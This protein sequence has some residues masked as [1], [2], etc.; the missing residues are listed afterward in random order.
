MQ[1]HCS[2]DL[3]FCLVGKWAQAPCEACGKGPGVSWCSY[4]GVSVLW[5]LR[6]ILWDLGGIIVRSWC[7]CSAILVGF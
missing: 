6:G 2:W 1:L 4:M 5:S 3:W 7:D